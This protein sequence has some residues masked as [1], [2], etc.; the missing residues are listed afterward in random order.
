MIKVQNQTQQS[1]EIEELISLSLDEQ[2]AIVGGLLPAI[3]IP[4]AF[5][6]ARLAPTVARAAPA[7]GGAVERYR[8]SSIHNTEGEWWSFL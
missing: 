1:T 5:T 7:I 4:A 8:N 2:D 6:A 3:L